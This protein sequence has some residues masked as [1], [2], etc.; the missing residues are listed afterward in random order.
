M[1]MISIRKQPLSLGKAVSH[2]RVKNLDSQPKASFNKKFL[3]LLSPQTCFS[4]SFPTRTAS[5]RV[6]GAGS[7][8]TAVRCRH[9]L[10][11]SGVTCKDHF[12]SGALAESPVALNSNLG[13]CISHV[14]E[15]QDNC[16]AF[17]KELIKQPLSWW[18]CIRQEREDKAVSMQAN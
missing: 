6:G 7:E 15:Q 11:S 1:S 13:T 14:V 3:P 17:H 4:C 18:L 5:S 12:G 8:S 10:S 9:I 2:C 16:K